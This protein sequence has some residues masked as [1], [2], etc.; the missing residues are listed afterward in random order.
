MSVRHAASRMPAYP[1]PR[2]P[3]LIPMLAKV[4]RSHAS[5]RLEGTCKAR[6]FTLGFCF[7]RAYPD[8]DADAC[9]LLSH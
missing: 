9:V 6:R 2:K 8:L 1:L 3:N 5:A 4:R 7:P